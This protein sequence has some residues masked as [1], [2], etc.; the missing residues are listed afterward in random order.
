M[1]KDVLS[2]DPV[3]IGDLDARDH[4]R[5]RVLQCIRAAGEISR[6]DIAKALISSPAT[7]TSAC[8]ALLDAGLIAETAA[9][10]SEGVQ[11]G[12]PRVM[13][14]VN[15]AVFAVAGVKIARDAI[16][17]MVVGFQGQEIGT[18]VW[19]LLESRMDPE[20]LVIEVRRALDAACAALDLPIERIAGL[21]IG[22]PGFLN[23]D[24]NF[25]HWSSSV[26]Q[27]NVDLGPL[28]AAHIP[29]PTFIDNDANLVAKAEHLFG[30]GR[31]FHNF[32]VVTL[33]HGVGMGII[34]NDQLYRGERGCGA[35]FGHM[36]IQFE[37]ALCQCG[38]RG[39]LEAYVGDYALIRD[40]GTVRG[41]SEIET[42]A[43]I[44][45]AARSGDTLAQEVL[46]R[47]SRVLGV[48]LANLVNLFDPEHIV[49][50]RSR[51]KFDQRYVDTMMATLRRNTVEVDAPLP[52]ITVRN[53]DEMM[54]AK[55]AAAHAIERVSILKVRGLGVADAV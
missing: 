54:W 5:L 15:G 42:I 10:P 34:L 55:G 16:R 11:R 14:T 22:L 24:E 38:Q 52:G 48:A 19:P 28:I 33:E 23:A 30:A 20:A 13:L 2:Q 51:P 26:T 32:L 40:S 27:G 31:G 3:L 4:T 49:V 44:I 46:D 47:A 25:L 7:V 12:R 1:T 53:L 21:T 50:A 39:C 45:A 8:G 43:D 9:P 37:G 41:Q 36:K 18:H 6:T 29:C 17:L 35:E